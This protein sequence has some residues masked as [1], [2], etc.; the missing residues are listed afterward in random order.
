MLP[1]MLMSNK[2]I[3]DKVLAG[4]GYLAGLGQLDI[5]QLEQTRIPVWAVAAAG[6]VLGLGAGIWIMRKLPASWVLSKEQRTR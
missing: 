3:T 2:R 4:A 1:L 5:R 6:A